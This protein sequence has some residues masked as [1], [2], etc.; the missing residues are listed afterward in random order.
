ME[1]GMIEADPVARVRPPKVY[2]PLPRFLTGRELAQLF[3]RTRGS[4]L[5]LAVFV[6]VA[7]GLRLSEIVGLRWRDVQGAGIVV[8]GTRQTKSGRA[9]VASIPPLAAKA[10]RRLAGP[11]DSPVVAVG[12]PLEA[13]RA[14]KAVAA[15][16]GAMGARA[17]T[18]SYWHLLRATW[19]VRMARR[20]WTVWELMSS[21]GWAG[22]Q[23]PLRYVSVAEAAR[24]IR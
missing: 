11:A 2:A 8:G 23:M 19:A 20:G 9:R 13:V 12:S 5:R 24:R 4:N 14:L 21:G 22:L 10:L 16:I 6:A 1:Q 15:G 3:G 18:G 17:G 7:A